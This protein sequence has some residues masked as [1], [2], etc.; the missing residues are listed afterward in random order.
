M[1][2]IGLT[3]LRFNN[4]YTISE[5]FNSFFAIFTFA[6]CILFPIAIGALYWYKIKSVIPLPDLDDR[7]QLE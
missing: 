3:D 5:Q 7:M 2:M 6:V 4:T 1:S